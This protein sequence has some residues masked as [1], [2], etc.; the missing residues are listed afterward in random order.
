MNKL[1]PARK[2]RSSPFAKNLKEILEA[3]GITQRG[4]AELAQVGVAVIN[5][6]LSGSIP[7]DHEAV[8]RLCRGLK[9]DF[10][11]ML[12][13]THTETK[14]K[15]MSIQEIFETENDPAFSGIF[16]IEAKRLKRRKE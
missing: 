7:H 5:D 15:E 13:N 9:T 12:T 4:A 1:K 11:W 6:W 14:I 16:Q 10:Q 3:R 2:K 8:L